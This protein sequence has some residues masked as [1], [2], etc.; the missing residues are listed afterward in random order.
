MH[1]DSRTPQ[2]APSILTD[3]DYANIDHA[4]GA[5]RLAAAEAAVDP[6]HRS[7]QCL[8]TREL[9]E[10]PGL[11]AGLS[12][13]MD[14]HAT[15]EWEDGPEAL[16]V[17]FLWLLCEGQALSTLGQRFLTASILQL[18]LAALLAVILGEEGGGDDEGA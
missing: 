3:T 7:P 13:L 2:H 15:R 14:T 5:F 1:T 4:L 17:A 18:D 11:A 10:V 9:R 6:C 16:L 12:A 8:V